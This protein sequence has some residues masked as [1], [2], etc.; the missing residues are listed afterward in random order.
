MERGEKGRRGLKIPF[1]RGPCELR[2]LVGYTS[3]C[4]PSGRV[5]LVRFS[6]RDPRSPMFAV[7]YHCRY[8]MLLSKHRWL[9]AGSTCGLVIHMQSVLYSLV[10]DGGQGADEVC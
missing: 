1:R 4:S 10:M 8:D 6:F 2:R 9:I 5:R 7:L 3:V